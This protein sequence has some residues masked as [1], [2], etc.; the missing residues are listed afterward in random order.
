MHDRYQDPGLLL[1]LTL[2]IFSITGCSK[3]DVSST[4]QNADRSVQLQKFQTV[5]VDQL[6]D[7]TDEL[8]RYWTNNRTF[9]IDSMCTRG[10]YAVQAIDSVSQTNLTTPMVCQM[11][12]TVSWTLTVPADG[13]YDV[14]FIPLLQDGSISGTIT[15]SKFYVATQPP[16]PPRIFNNNGLSFSTTNP[17]VT[18]HLT[19]VSPS[20]SIVSTEYGDLW[21]NRSGQYFSLSTELMGGQSKLFSFYAYDY[22]GNQSAPVQI[23]VSY[24]QNYLIALT[25]FSAVNSGAPLQATHNSLF[26]TNANMGAFSF[27]YP[28]AA[29]GSTTD[30]TYRKLEVESP[31][32]EIIQSTAE[33]E[34]N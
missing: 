20:K 25:Q 19:L 21:N 27:A 22:A 30:P 16:S 23:T 17:Y 31:Q 4:Q 15:Y 13:E 32:H 14:S 18:L 7:T 33:S 8:G 24:L 5:A 6:G 9:Q 3:I 12:R 29:G 11:D 1:C 28:A 26:L 2:S 34:T 10:V